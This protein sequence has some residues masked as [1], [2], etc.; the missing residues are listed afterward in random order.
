[1]M[2][3]KAKFEKMGI[4]AEF[5]GEAQDCQ[6]AIANVIAGRIQLLFISR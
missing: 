6:E 5:V 1:M 3:Q 2:D 4:C